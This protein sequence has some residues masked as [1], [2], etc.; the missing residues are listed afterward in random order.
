MK[1]IDIDLR[2][3]YTKKQWVYYKYAYN[4]N[5]SEAFQQYNLLWMCAIKA[6]NTI[7]PLSELFH[8]HNTPKLHVFEKLWQLCVHIQP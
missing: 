1:L 5:I 7:N 2:W 6:N 4:T 8:L 3:Y